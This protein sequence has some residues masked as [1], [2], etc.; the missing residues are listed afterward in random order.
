MEGNETESPRSSEV[1]RLQTSSL[2]EASTS[3][4]SAFAR[5]QGAEELRWDRELAVT[6][7]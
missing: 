1:N 5:S 2:T 6:E 4:E 7:V 3:D